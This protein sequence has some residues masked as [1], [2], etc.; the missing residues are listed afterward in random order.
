MGIGITAMSKATRV[1]CSGE[2]VEGEYDVCLEEHLTID[3]PARRRDGVK[4]GC[5]M[6]G[7]GGRETGTVPP[8]CWPE[9]GRCRKTSWRSSARRFAR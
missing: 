6:V 8:W 3:A 1:S 7:R 2:Y 5:Y 9:R 4:P